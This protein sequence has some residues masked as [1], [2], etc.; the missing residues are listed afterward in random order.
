MDNTSEELAE[1]YDKRRDLAEQIST[2]FGDEEPNDGDGGYQD[3]LEQLN[4]IE[5]QINEF[6]NN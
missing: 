1:L 3:L 5:E 6:N 4:S 2:Y